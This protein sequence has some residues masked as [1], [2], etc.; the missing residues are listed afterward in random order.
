MPTFRRR[1]LQNGSTVYQVQV[2]L[3]GSAPVTRTFER[4]TDARQWGT[5][6]EAAVRTGRELS[7]GDRARPAPRA[8]RTTVG[9]AIRR[10]IEEYLPSVAMTDRPNRI[11][12]LD[13]WLE[14]I[15]TVPLADLR[16]PA[17][18]AARENL[19]R[20]VRPATVNRYVAA[21]SHVLSIATRDWEWLKANPALKLRRLKEPSGRVRHLS[22]SELEALLRSC[23]Q[24]AN[25]RLELL[26]LAALVTGAREGELLA[27]RWRDID[28]RQ[29]LI[30][31]RRSKNDD[32]KTVPMVDSLVK[33]FER[34]VDEINSDRDFVFV[35][36][37]GAPNFPRKA[38]ETA[39]RNAKVEDFRFHDLRHTAAS[40]LAMS[41]AS[42]REIQQVLGHRTPQMTARYAHLTN[43]HLREVGERMSAKFLDPAVKTL[44]K[45]QEP[46]VVLRTEEIHE[47]G[48]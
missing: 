10:Y 3:G 48:S 19:S 8:K 27:L 47:G 14:R 32:P 21:L 42:L 28:L 35:T 22:D 43:G 5:E 7:V 18:A 20:S 11:R 24:S 13:W 41:G 12:Q 39:L 38:W 34:F 4:L 1:V 33:R 2:R 9:D 37:R 16:P 36:E 44:A 15:G 25:P 6:A 40:Y 17:I 30:H 46:Q 45:G 31:F 26:V 23:E 29:G